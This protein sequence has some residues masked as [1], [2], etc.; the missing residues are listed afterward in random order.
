M[1]ELNIK[2]T[3][4]LIPSAPFNFDATVFKPDHFPSTDNAWEPGIR[5][6]TMR[7]EGQY[8]G[9]KLQNKGSVEQPCLVL[10]VFS[11]MELTQDFLSRLAAEIR[12]RYNLDMELDKFYCQFQNDPN[13]GPV[14]QRW[15]GMRPMNPGSLYEY[16][17][18][19]IV[20]QNATVRRSVNMLQA[21]FDAYGTRLC[22][23][24]QEFSAFW[25]PDTMDAATEEELRALKVGY[26]A[27]SLKRVS[28]AFTRGEIDEMDLRGKTIEEQRQALLKL[29]GIGP[30]SVGYLL[31][32]VFHQLEKME[33]IS[34]WG[35]KIYSKLFFDIDPDTPVPVE[36]LLSYFNQHF[37]Q[38]RGL[39]VHYFWEDLFWRRQHEPVDWLE[40]LIRL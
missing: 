20:L 35:Q 12:F 19:A 1:K 25:A 16:I 3:I 37:G 27:K 39:A 2:T 14:I 10:T 7:W 38:Y 23:D 5:W 15:R 36:K 34:P 9:Y 17:V 6:Q 8:L 26:R 13:L 29:Y 31:F 28:A 21:L 33:H 40:K 24:D 4:E 11:D 30:A 32:D 22:F 18:I